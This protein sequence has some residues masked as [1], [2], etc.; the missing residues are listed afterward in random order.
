MKY[1]E[2]TNKNSLSKRNSRLVKGGKTEVV[3]GKLGWWERKND[4]LNN[5]QDDDILY[6]IPID[7]QYRP[8]LVAFL[9]YGTTELEWVVLQ[10]NNI[11][12]IIEEFSA[13]KQI[14]LPNP[15]SVRNYVYSRT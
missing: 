12:D 2:Y 9:L 4:N 5:S 6:T 14:R 7:Y 10:Y 13:G 1:R 11:V 8:D 15:D 3:G